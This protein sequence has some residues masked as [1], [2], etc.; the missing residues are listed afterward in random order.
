MSSGLKDSIGW[1]TAV[2]SSFNGF[3]QSQ[4]RVGCCCTVG[5]LVLPGVGLSAERVPLSVSMLDAALAC[6]VILVLRVTARLVRRRRE[7]RPIERQLPT[8]L[9]IGAEA[10][11]QMVAR[12]LFAQ[13]KSGLRPVGFLDDEPRKRGMVIGDLPVVGGIDDLPQ[14]AR[15][16]GVRRVV[17][18]MPSRRAL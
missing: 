3:L 15:A 11:G 10:A 14:A 5:T 1:T 18:A 16:L 2:E 17:I 9:I 7:R 4:R 8:A 13:P 12:E 6:G